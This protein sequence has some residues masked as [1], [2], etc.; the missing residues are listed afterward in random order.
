ML[1]DDLAGRA[2]STWCTITRRATWRRRARN[3]FATAVLADLHWQLT[4]FYNDIGPLSIDP[5]LMKGALP[6]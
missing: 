3:V 1:R 5:E 6:M 2:R 4:P